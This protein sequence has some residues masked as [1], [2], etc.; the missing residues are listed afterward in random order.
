MLCKIHFQRV[1][2]EH[3]KNKV[4]LK[5][6]ESYLIKALLLAAMIAKR[7]KRNDRMIKIRNTMHQIFV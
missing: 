4:L 6:K 1:S 2:E 5:S 3:V 7:Q